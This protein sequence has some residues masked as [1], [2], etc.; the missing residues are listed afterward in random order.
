MPPHEVVSTAGFASLERVKVLEKS[1]N[2]VTLEFT[3]PGT[4]PYFDGHFPGLPIL[5]AVAQMEMVLRFAA[6]HLGTNVDVSEIGRIKFTNYFTPGKIHLLGLE[7]KDEKL[8]FKIYSPGG[9]T[10]YSS[11]F[12]TLRE[13]L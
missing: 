13:F 10:V 2:S 9:G 5:P 12:V 6:E 8:S 3:L 4:S 7:K 11:G 1:E